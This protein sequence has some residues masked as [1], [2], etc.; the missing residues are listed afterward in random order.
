[1]PWVLLVVRNEQLRQRFSIPEAREEIEE[2]LIDELGK[3]N[4][5][6]IEHESDLAFDWLFPEYSRASA[7][8]MVAIAY[9]VRRNGLVPMD[10]GDPSFTK[11]EAERLLALMK[12]K[13]F[14]NY[15]VGPWPIPLWH[16]GYAEG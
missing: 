5:L 7:D 9:S 13:Y 12:E 3:A 10:A 16:A 4:S 8:V 2:F 15:N 1:M 6:Q 11:E 14:P